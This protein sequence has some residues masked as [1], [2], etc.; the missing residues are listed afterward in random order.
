MLRVH[1]F[2]LARGEAEKFSIKPVYTLQPRRCRHK[3]RIGAQGIGNA[4]GRQFLWRE[5]ANGLPSLA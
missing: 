5:E 4:H 1:H 3:M 2:R